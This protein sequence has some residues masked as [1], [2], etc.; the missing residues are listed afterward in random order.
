[1]SFIVDS[2]IKFL[3]KIKSNIG[4]YSEPVVFPIPISKKFY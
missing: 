2:K 1:M 4:V 3:T